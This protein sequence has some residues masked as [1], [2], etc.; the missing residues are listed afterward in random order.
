MRW[1]RHGA[2]I[3]KTARWKALRQLAKRRDGFA[4]VKCGSC[5]RLQVDHVK[6]L[7]SDPDRAFDIN[8]TQTLCGTC[9]SKKTRVECGHPE[10]SPERQQWREFMRLRPPSTLHTKETPNA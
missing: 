8:N 2:S 1:Q 5:Q 9:H 6:P 4:C 3:Y 10:L 7:R